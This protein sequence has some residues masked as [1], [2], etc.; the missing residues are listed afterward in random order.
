MASTATQRIIRDE[1]SGKPRAISNPLLAQ[2]IK[3]GTYFWYESFTSVGNYSCP[4]VITR[5]NH[6][7]RTFRI[8]SLDDM[9]EQTQEYSFDVGEHSPGSRQTM[10][11]VDEETVRL[12]LIERKKSL[13]MEPRQKRIAA[14]RAD[15]ALANFLE[16]AKKLNLDLEKSG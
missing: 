3:V 5:V 11:L 14:D 15:A 4:G 7:R 12:Y 10:R 1:I 8:R 16:E 9:R 2:H 13:E 6:S